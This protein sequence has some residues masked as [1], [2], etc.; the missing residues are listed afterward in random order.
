MGVWIRQVDGL[1]VEPDGVEWR[2][3]LLEGQRHRCQGPNFLPRLVFASP[4]CRIVYIVSWSLSPPR[5][6]EPLRRSTNRG[7]KTPV[8][9]TS[10]EVDSYDVEV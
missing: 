8:T 2:D 7:Q 4:R 10:K 1:L 9:S 3:V 5:L 6:P